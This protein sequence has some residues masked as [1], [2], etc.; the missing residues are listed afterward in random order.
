M[1]LHYKYIKEGKS[2]QLPILITSRDKTLRAMQ[3]IL[4]E[5]LKEIDRI[6]R[7]HGIEYSLS[8]GT[9]L[10]QVRHGGFIPWDDD[11]DVDMM[12]G[13]FEKFMAIAPKELDSSRFF[14]YTRES[15]PNHYR[16]SARLGILG[17]RLSLG[18]WGGVGREINFFVDIFRWNYLPDDE[19]ERQK[20]TARLFLIR[21]IQHFK[22][23]H[24][25]PLLLEPKH[26][27][28]VKTMSK[29]LSGRFLERAEERLLNS[30]K[31]PTGWLID[32][33]IIKGDFGGFPSDGV[34]EV[35]DVQF[36]GY[37]FMGKKDPHNYLCALY[38]P[39]YGEWLPPA[40]R[41]SHHT[42]SV[43]DLGDYAAKYG[44]SENYKEFMTRDF[45]PGKLRQ[46]KKVSDM[47]VQ[48]VFDICEKHGL[49]C[50]LADITET[51]VN[52]S[53]PGLSELWLR[54]AT[55]MMLREDYEKFGEICQEEFGKQFFYQTHE[56]EPGYCYDYA[57][58]R[59]NFTRNRDRRI[60]SEIERNLNMGFFIKV[61]PLDNY[62][63][64]ADTDKKLKNLRFW[65][66]SLWLKW[67]TTDA[68]IFLN[69]S[70]KDKLRLI[71]LSTYSM[72]DVIEKVTK[73][74]QVYNDRESD[75]CFDSTYQLDGKVFKKE[76]I[77]G[78]SVL[79]VKRSNIKAETIDD[80]L[81]S[82]RKRF[83]SCQLTYYDEPDYQLSILRYDEKADRLLTVEEILEMS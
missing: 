56:T 78:N 44:V 51:T 2:M 61:I 50:T 65:R 49:H 42:W 17:T 33:T 41:I 62:V 70:F 68:S 82:V 74:A 29:V 47:M 8:G 57:R 77:M 28:F 64:E 19:K 37:T 69:R 18:N 52:Q 35:K 10:G 59:L 16:S 13:E 26:R 34:E 21:S 15:E 43:F 48:K 54:P 36:E 23:V 46:M 81:D 39:H 71:G 6:C 58:V 76:K 38:G 66:R 3:E 75:S 25:Y 9:C 12:A 73:C 80:I 63:K 40:K 55:V 24:R 27:L 20:L 1:K 4:L 14:L 60:R 72:D 30:V 53:I 7:K 79:S 83:V 32:N 5:G 67:W 45:T 22:E 31:G 11:I